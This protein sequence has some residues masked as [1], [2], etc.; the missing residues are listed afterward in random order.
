MA[1]L[2]KLWMTFFGLVAATLL[3]V[4]AVG[5]LLSGWYN[6]REGFRRGIIDFII[7]ICEFVLLEPL[8]IGCVLGTI[9]LYL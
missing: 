3:T 6:W 1:L 8:A 4:V 9:E 7:G 5:G 2:T